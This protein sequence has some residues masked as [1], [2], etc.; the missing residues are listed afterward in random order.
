MCLRLPI[1]TRWEFWKLGRGQTHTRTHNYYTH[2]RTHVA[3]PFT[4]PPHMTIMRVH[5]DRVRGSTLLVCNVR[6]FFLSR[7]C[8]CAMFP[9]CTRLT[10]CSVCVF[11]VC[12]CVYM[13]CVNS[14]CM[15]Y[16]CIYVSV[17]F[18]CAYHVCVFCVYAA[19][20]VCVYSVRLLCVL[21]VCTLWCLFCGVY[22]SCDVRAML[23]L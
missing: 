22:S 10:M 1:A 13:L 21:C 9:T 17:C 3:T 16:T 6:V 7:S 15:L 19:C 4:S 8:S 20:V 23:L 2:T 12:M 14:L 5:E 18:L 11:C